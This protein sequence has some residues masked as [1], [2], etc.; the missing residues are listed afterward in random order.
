ML[1][2]NIVDKIYPEGGG[3]MLGLVGVP[4][5]LITLFI[6]LVIT[7]KCKEVIFI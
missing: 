7:L 6:F 4:S 2:S 5:V 3:V 1:L